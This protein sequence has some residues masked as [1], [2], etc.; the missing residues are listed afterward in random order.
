MQVHVFPTEWGVIADAVGVTIPHV[1]HGL[2]I[3]RLLILLNQLFT[4]TNL[5]IIIKLVPETTNLVL[6]E[7]RA[8][9]AV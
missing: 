8:T 4:K 7:I 6:L 1:E 3:D 9:N 5:G 2:D